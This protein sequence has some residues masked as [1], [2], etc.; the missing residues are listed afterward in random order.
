MKH[1]MTGVFMLNACFHFKENRFHMRNLLEFFAKYHHW[2]LFLLLEIISFV[3]LFQYNSYQSSVW[4]SSANVVMGKVYEVESHVSSYFKLS[5]QNE[6]LAQQ[7]ILLTRRI[8]ALSEQL[9]DKRQEIRAKKMKAFPA[10]PTYRQISAKVVSNSVH[11]RDNF[12]TIDKGTKD[13]VRR[14]MGVICGSGVVGIVYL[15][16][17][18]YSVVIPVLNSKSNI[19][20]K[21]QRHG[22]FGYLHWTGGATDIA[23]VDDIPRHAHFRIG[24]HVVTSGYSSV[25]PPGILVGK[26]QHVYNSKDALSYRLQVKLSTDFGNLRDV[27]VIDDENREEQLEL[28]RTVQDSLKPKQA[29]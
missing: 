28:L 24:D 16:S 29:S 5:Q 4:F 22:Y 10:Q 2:F 18:H 6:R 20:C 8:D 7:N 23:Y 9:I 3:L 14:D 1:C 21:I 25:F 27:F 15:C 11:L 13:G 19:S 12:I 17:S 26:I